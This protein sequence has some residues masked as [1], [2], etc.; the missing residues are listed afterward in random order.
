V[1]LARGEVASRVL[2]HEVL[3]LYGAIHVNPDVESLMNPSG[4]SLT[5]DPW[6]AAIVSA[7]R[8]RRFG[9]GG[10]EAN[11]LRH[12]NLRA[13]IAAYHAALAAN[14]A[15]RNAG[16]VAALETGH[17]SLR[18]AAPQAR[19]ALQLD[20]HLGDVADLAAQLLLR[21]GRPAGAVRAWETAAALYGIESSRGRRA[22][23]NAVAT[24]RSLGR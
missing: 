16:V 6:N 13:T 11:V 21:D 7:T 19:N 1:R 24:A 17:G 3:H 2:A 8:K 23:Q 15:L 5:I 22:L 10:I 12:A 20:E 4:H 9:P 18:A 14:V